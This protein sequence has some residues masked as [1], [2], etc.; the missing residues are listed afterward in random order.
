MNSASKHAVIALLVISIAG[1]A[2]KKAKTAPPA[3]AQAPAIPAAGKAG[4]MYPPPLT[5]SQ[6]QT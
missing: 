2:D 3:Q 4:A 5:E 1:C 6:T